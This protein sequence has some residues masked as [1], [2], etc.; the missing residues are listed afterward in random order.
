MNIISGG[1]IITEVETLFKGGVK[2]VYLAINPPDSGW[3]SHGITQ[4]FTC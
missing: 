1:S 4:R 2:E 3:R